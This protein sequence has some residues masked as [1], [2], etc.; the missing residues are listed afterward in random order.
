MR[1]DLVVMDLT[2][3]SVVLYDGAADTMIVLTIAAEQRVKLPPAQVRRVARRAANQ[4]VIPEVEAVQAAPPVP[5]SKLEVPAVYRQDDF[6]PKPGAPNY[7]E[8]V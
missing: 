8:Q 5:Q 7:W 4:T 3:D 6:A 2:P 1:K